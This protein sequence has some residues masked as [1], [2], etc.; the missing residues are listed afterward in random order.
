MFCKKCGSE[1]PE[2]K[3]FCAD[4][5]T[6]VNSEEKN[7]KTALIIVSCVAVIA[8]VGVIVLGIKLASVNKEKQTTTTAT[9][10]TTTTTKLS[11]TATTEA[12]TTAETT[13]EA[14]T[15][16]STTTKKPTVSEPIIPDPGAYLRLARN[17]DGIFGSDDNPYYVISYRTDLSYP[18]ALQE[19]ITLISDERY[20][21]KLV[22]THESYFSSSYEYYFNYTG[23]K[24]I[25]N[26][27]QIGK[28][29]PSCDLVVSISYF[30]ADEPGEYDEAYLSLRFSP[31]APF[32]LVDPGKRTSFILR[33][34]S[35][36][37]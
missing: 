37:S 28:N 22:S 31:D 10:T 14:T 5:G 11:T 17:E 2:G 21:F 30:P 25:P 9:I 29:E 15:K 23:Q 3:K 6:A 16:K 19:Y 33:D 4:C 13:T 1:I 36:L 12:P 7:K 8:I 32:K 20:P 35:Y 24:D 34:L 26:V 18:Q 27:A